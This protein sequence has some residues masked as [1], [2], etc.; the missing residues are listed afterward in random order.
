MKSW[1]KRLSLRKIGPVKLFGIGLPLA[2]LFIQLLGP[3]KTNPPFETSRT[4]AA[5]LRVTTQVKGILERACQNCHSHETE[6]PWYSNVAPVSWFV[7]DHVDH[8][9][10]EMNFSNWAQY[11]RKKMITRLEEM[12]ELVTEAEM[13]LP[14]YLW[15]HDEAHLTADDVR[16]LCEWSAAEQ[17]RLMEFSI[18]SPEE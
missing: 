11:D 5:Q 9:R 16:T 15:M 12:C 7:I 17:E 13:P 3:V 10:R 8:A 6:W 4:L 14:P 2:F 1:L 18:L